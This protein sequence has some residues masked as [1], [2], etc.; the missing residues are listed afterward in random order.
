MRSTLLGMVALAGMLL[1]PFAAEAKI[2]YGSL[3]FKNAYQY[4]KARVQIRQA[5]AAELT[6]RT[7]GNMH[8]SRPFTKADIR[9]GKLSVSMIE[10]AVP[11]GKALLD[12]TWKTKGSTWAGHT[13]PIVG[14]KTVSLLGLEIERQPR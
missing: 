12:T 2:N 13:H 5:V 10:V 3:G 9:L 7:Q 14:G 1:A 8:V 4:G 6:E 11:S